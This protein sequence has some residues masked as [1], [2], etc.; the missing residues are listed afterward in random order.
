MPAVRFSQ[1]DPKTRGKLS[2]P[3]M[4]VTAAKSSDPGGPF[5][6][7][8]YHARLVTNVR[9][10]AGTL[11]GNTW[12]TGEKE[13]DGQS[14]NAATDYGAS[15]N[16]SGYFNGFDLSA[17]SSIDRIYWYLSEGDG[18]DQVSGTYVLRWEGGGGL[19]PGI[20]NSSLKTPL[21]DFDNYRV[22]ENIDPRTVLQVSFDGDELRAVSGA[23]LADPFTRI[24]LEPSGLS[25]TTHYGGGNLLREDWKQAF[26]D[27]TGGLRMMDF[28]TTNEQGKNTSW[29]ARKIP[30]Y[31]TYAH[32][33]YNGGFYNHAPNGAP[34]EVAVQICNELQ[35][36]GWFNC[37]WYYVSAGV[38]GIDQPDV[39]AWA[40]AICENYN[41][42][43]NGPFVVEYSNENWNGIFD[44]ADY[45][46]SSAQVLSSLEMAEYGETR[47]TD[48]NGNS[49]SNTSDARLRYTAMGW[50]SAEM[51]RAAKKVFDSYGVDYHRTLGVHT[52][53]VG[54]T[55]N[56][57][58][59]K[60]VSIDPGGTDNAM[61]EHDSVS[62]TG[63]WG[64]W[65]LTEPFFS[66][67]FDVIEPYTEQT[68]TTGGVPW[69]TWGLTGSA[70]GASEQYNMTS[71]VILLDPLS[72][73]PGTV[74]GPQDPVPQPSGTG[75]EEITGRP[76]ET[77]DGQ[78]RA[79]HYQIH[80][81]HNDESA[82]DSWA[83]LAAG[84]RA[85]G[86]EEV[87]CYEGNHH[88]AWAG[89][90]RP[91]NAVWTTAPSGLGGWSVQ[92]W[93][94]SIY[95]GYTRESFARNWQ[96]AFTEW[97]YHFSGGAYAHFVLNTSRNYRDGW[98]GYFS[99]LDVC[100]DVD[101][102]ARDNLSNTFHRVIA[103]RRKR[104]I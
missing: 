42:K 9:Y 87:L 46:L 58:I 89:T 50:L 103:K 31:R 90:S 34:I 43:A 101:S 26:A 83:Q 49:F 10:K 35:L 82:T 78:S 85:R 67:R 23:Y 99:G 91:N 65:L 19:K 21:E 18:L 47:F 55:L 64:T 80:T 25:G 92:S 77:W 69:S 88:V 81:Y 15:L 102:P 95:D 40:S 32:G 11:G 7:L 96:D 73:I 20:R 41:H 17:L 4:N 56:F 86:I 94:S 13:W 38:G 37:P 70:T 51:M 44:A 39:S 30:E 72:A 24:V 5:N 27:Y 48:I 28:L 68:G 104:N 61:T 57:T 100:N 97:N 16:A 79:L 14:A 22:Y 63:Y 3:V 62:I 75:L 93:V 60:T 12:G 52:G 66:D 74:G 59:D 2:K 54:N 71:N 8:M 98:W 76:E 33:D 6:N 29:A 36:P 45:A 84:F 1:P 53:G